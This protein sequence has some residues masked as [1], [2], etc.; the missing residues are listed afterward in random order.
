VL[1]TLADRLTRIE[2]ELTELRLAVDRVRSYAEQTDR[3][4]HEA[5]GR[6]SMCQ[7]GRPWPAGPG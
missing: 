3:L 5:I 1:L 2:R 6:L 4:H 7:S